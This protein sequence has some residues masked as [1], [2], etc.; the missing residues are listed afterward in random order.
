MCIRDSVDPLRDIRRLTVDCCQNGA[1]FV[2]EADLG[3]VVADTTHGVLRDL[4]IVDVRFGGDF[5][6]NDDQTRRY[7]RFA[8]HPGRRVVGND[9]V[10]DLSLIHI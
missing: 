8:G 4:A 5:T 1:A 7:Q 2:V 10:E 3:V 9:G 6:R